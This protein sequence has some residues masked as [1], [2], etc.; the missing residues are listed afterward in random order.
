[1]SLQIVTFDESHLDDAA[2]VL[3]R[4]QA[5][6]REAEPA[7]P[8]RFTDPH[9]ARELVAEALAAPESHGV[10]AILDG[11]LVAYLLGAPRYEPIWNR[12]A[13]SPVEGQALDPGI[14]ADLMRDVYAAW[15]PHWVERGFF[16]HYVHAPAHDGQLLDAWSDLNF[17]RMQ[18]H[19]VRDLDERVEAPADPAFEIRC[20]GP[21]DAEGIAPLYDLIAR[22]Q[23]LAPAYAITLPERY[24]AF[25]AD[26][27]EDIA[28]PGSHYWVAFEGERPIGLA[29][30]Y[31]TEPAVMTPDGAWELG[32]ALGRARLL[33]ALRPRAC[34][35]CSAPRRL[36]RPQLRQDAGARRLRSRR[37]A[38]SARGS[39]VRDS[40]H[41]SR[42]CGV[43][44]AAV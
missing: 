23:V 8:Q 32:A 29:G 41:R 24:A 26:Y 14:D 37:A 16:L 28:D 7:L 5:R 40:V 42:G 1:M 3:A 21:E 38:R 36:V 25:P 4:R 27:A 9:H 19:A 11:R 22:H 2:A 33:P 15:A 6:L 31:E 13:W 34:A 30:F 35:R 18:A 20:I 43:H 12:A 17:G 10:V 44:R 39:R